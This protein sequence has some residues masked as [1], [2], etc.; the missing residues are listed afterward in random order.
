PTVYIET[1][2]VSILRSRPS[3]RVVSAA[4][5]LLTRRWWN[6]ERRNYDLFTTQFVLDEASQGDPQL[7]AERLE[8]LA[9]IPLL[10]LPQE[11]PQIADEL[12]SRAVLPP[13]ARLDALHI[14]AA[15]YHEIDYLLTWNCTHIANARLIPKV[16]RV[17]GELGF[18]PPHICT[19]E[20]LL[21][22]EN[23][24]E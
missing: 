24:T 17:V 4:R 23:D 3:G 8:A 7:A 10:D 9:G 11:I 18:S 20:E 15:T 12:L 19:P 2:I 21:D 6:T 14:S 16:R 22:D 5:Q 1:S 13:K